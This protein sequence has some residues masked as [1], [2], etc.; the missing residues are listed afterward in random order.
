MKTNYRFIKRKNRNIEVVFNIAPDK[1]IST[2]TKDITE[3]VTFAENYLRRNGFCGDSSILLKDYAKDFFMKDDIGSLRYRHRMFEKEN[4]EIWYKRRQ[5]DLDA[6][7]IPYFGNFRLDYITPP[8]IETWLIQ[9]K[10]KKNIQKLCG[11]TKKKILYALREVLDSAVRE[12]YIA[13]NPSR[14]VMIPS[15]KVIYERR[16]LTAYEQKV[17]FPNSKEERIKVWENLTYAAYFSTMYDTGFRPGEL[18]GLRVC[19]IYR[20][21]QGVGVFTSHSIN[22]IERKEKARV[23]TSGKGLESRVGL[24][25][26]VTEDLIMEII[27]SKKLKDDDYLFLICYT[28]KNSWICNET[29]NKILRRICLK[30]KIDIK[31]IYQ[32]SLRH[33]Y[34]TYRRGNMDEATLALS[35]GHSGGRVRNDYDHRTASILLAQLEKSRDAIFSDDD[36]EEEIKPLKEKRG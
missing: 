9:L 12:Q 13:S 3:A 30:H 24:L 27:K 5:S 31:G 10:P 16:C 7:I 28:R 14:N 19:D 1:H 29:A 11:N 22:F 36:K 6:Y 32:Y 17:L 2:G 15:Q 26:S 35:M 33:T 34:A 8:M 23:K 18:A 4:E 25:T 21:P 20:T